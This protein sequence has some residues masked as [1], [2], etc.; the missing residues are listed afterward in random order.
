MIEV[1]A[2]IA[3]RA[4]LGATVSESRDPA[5]LTRHADG[6]SDPSRQRAMRVPPSRRP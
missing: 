1:R 6:V 5:A 3:S 2:R 4:A